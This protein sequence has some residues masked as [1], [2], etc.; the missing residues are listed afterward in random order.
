M[1][2]KQLLTD[3]LA[4]PGKV[5]KAHVPALLDLLAQ[6]PYVQPIHLLLAK[7]DAD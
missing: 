4:Q 6:F 5:R 7:A 1:N 3:L 2:N